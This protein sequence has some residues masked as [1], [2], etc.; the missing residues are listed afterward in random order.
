MK[1]MRRAIDAA[2]AAM[3]VKLTTR[4]VLASLRGSALDQARA[5]IID[6]AQ[7]MWPATLLENRASLAIMARMLP[8]EPP[9]ARDRQGLL[10]GLLVAAAVAA[11]ATA[12]A[13]AIAALLPSRRRS[14]GA[15]AAAPAFRPVVIPVSAPSEEPL[16][17]PP[18]EGK[19]D[20]LDA[21]AAEELRALSDTTGAA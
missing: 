18:E 5:A 17:T 9:P 21:E 20:Q 12:I 2:I 3:V 10:K 14:R 13:F 16:S 11:V 7:T 4:R 6:R 19:V 8:P 1:P 15:D